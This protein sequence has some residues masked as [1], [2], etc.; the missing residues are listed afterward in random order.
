MKRL[1]KINGILLLV[2]SIFPAFSG[3]ATITVQPDRNPAVSQESFQL[4]FEAVGEV[5]GD[6]DFSPLEKDFQ[7]LS[8]STSSSMSIVNT[9][10][11]RTRQ[12]RLTPAAVEKRQPD[13][14][15][16]LFRQG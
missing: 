11:T 15:R 8:T 14:P 3:A 2:L 12:W 4:L 16:H 13:H 10:I 7:V 6:P 5:D 9:N 1:G